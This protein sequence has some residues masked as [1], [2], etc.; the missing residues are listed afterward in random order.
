MTEPTEPREPGTPPPRPAPEAP[1]APPAALSPATALFE[2]GDFLAARREVARVLAATSA[3]T[4]ASELEAAARALLERMAP[5][6]WAVRIGL[7][8]LV[9]LALV[10]GLYVR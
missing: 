8:V 3:T 9:L 4:T 1:A 10:T 6:R 7:L 2:R 5:D